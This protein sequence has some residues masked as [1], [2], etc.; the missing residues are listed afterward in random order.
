[1]RQT[2]LYVRRTR[3]AHRALLCVIPYNADLAPAT[4]PLD[5]RQ[6]LAAAVTAWVFGGVGSWNDIGFA[7][8]ARR[9]GHDPLTDTLYRSVLAALV[10]VAVTD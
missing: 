4:L 3:G 7:N 1:M 8:T 5:A 9:S 2:L 10:A 6:L